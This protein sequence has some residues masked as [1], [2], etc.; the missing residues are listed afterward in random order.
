MTV[1][2]KARIALDP[3]KLKLP[4]RPKIDDIQVEEY[5]DWEGEDALRVQVILAEDTTDDDLTGE[6]AIDL[7]SAIHDALLAQGIEEFPYVFV[8]KRS[9]LESLDGAE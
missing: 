5:A 4:P 2:E 6:S 9:E 1:V 8:A 3:K 7:K